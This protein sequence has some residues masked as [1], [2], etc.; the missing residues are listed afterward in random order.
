M[1]ASSTPVYIELS[2]NVFSA[3]VFLAQDD[4]DDE[5]KNYYRLFYYSLKKVDFDNDNFE[6]FSDE[7][8]DLM[9]EITCFPDLGML[10]ELPMEQKTNILNHLVLYGKLVASVAVIFKINSSGT[11]WKDAIMPST[12]SRQEKD[13]NRF[14]VFQGRFKYE[15]RIS[16]SSVFPLMIDIQKSHLWKHLKFTSSPMYIF[17]KIFRQAYRSPND[18][19][20]TRQQLEEFTATCQDQ[21]Y[22]SLF[23]FT[24]MVPNDNQIRF[25][26]NVLTR[27]KNVQR[28]KS[29]WD[30]FWLNQINHV[31]FGYDDDD[32]GN[33][34]EVRLIMKVF[35]C[36]AD[37]KIE[38]FSILD[39]LE[40][41]NVLEMNDNLDAFI[42]QFII[43]VQQNGYDTHF[44]SLL[45]AIQ[46]PVMEQEF[47]VDTG[48]Y[49]DRFIYYS[50][51]IQL[52]DEDMVDHYVQEDVIEDICRSH[53]VDKDCD[54]CTKPPKNPQDRCLALCKSSRQQ[55]KRERLVEQG[56][57]YCLQH[58]RK[59]LVHPIMI[60][61]KQFDAYNVKG[62]SKYTYEL[63]PD[64][65]PNLLRYP[66]SKRPI[67]SDLLKLSR[68]SCGKNEILIPVYRVHSLYFKNANE[69]AWKNDPKYCGKFWFYDVDSAVYLKLGNTRVFGSKVSAYATLYQ[70]LAESLP[71][72]Q[73][74]KLEM[75]DSKG[76]KKSMEIIRENTLPPLSYDDNASINIKDKV[77]RSLSGMENDIAAKFS[78]FGG[79]QLKPVVIAYLL[80]FEPLNRKFT[81][82]ARYNAG[83]IT[84]YFGNL[85]LSPLKYQ[86]GFPSINEQK[87]DFYITKKY[88][89]TGKNLNPLFPS[90][91][92]DFDSDEDE[93]EDYKTNPKILKNVEAGQLDFLDAAICRLAR[94]L[95][96]D[97]VILQHEVGS[98]D[99][100]TEVLD[101]RENSVDHICSIDVTDS[102]E[103]KLHQEKMFPKIWFLENGIIVSK[104]TK[105]AGI[106]GAHQA[107]NVNISTGELR[108]II[109]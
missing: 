6:T 34:E 24:E 11:F 29:F 76:N 32:V 27:M 51:L 28:F 36:I 87:N 38:H 86:Q 77:V 68:G 4:H 42:A 5:D 19:I 92:Y 80:L 15:S 90:A 85:L 95:K 69:N 59:A 14:N 21:T 17:T 31:P 91:P 71:K 43:W 64:E 8:I 79:L 40:E 39:S 75:K 13:L 84:N 74:T 16:D 22:C 45:D 104:E 93:D 66:L 108:V 102:A 7:N 105:Q 41:G 107:V 37:K 109:T 106:V 23:L 88:P 65:S 78:L 99:A 73:K 54:A 58:Y 20:V 62:T 60:F 1:A 46:P 48:E 100:V 55:C 103:K 56:H 98:F 96:I 49:Q 30:Y 67:N 101:A 9:T 2:K 33:E 72:H 94:L 12:L 35:T 89:K 61:R 52:A 53:S 44:L 82:N 3:F 97:T 25:I 10:Q 83:L 81:D 26:C 63:T 18:E 50:K 47:N 57:D 70:E